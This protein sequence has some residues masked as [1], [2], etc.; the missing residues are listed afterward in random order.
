[1]GT[2]NMTRRNLLISLA[3]VAGWLAVSPVASRAAEPSRE[4]ILVLGDSITAAGGYVRAI[5][6]AL[7]KQDPKNAPRVVNRGRNSETVSGLSEAYHPGFRPCIFLRLDKVLNDTKPNWVL[8]CYGINCGIYHPFDE[9]RFAAY[10]AGIEKLIKKVHASG[11]RL[12]LF[13]PPPYA[14]SGPAFPKDA[15]AA[16]CKKLLAAASAKAAAEADKNPRK[17]GY[18]TPYAYYDSVMTRYAKW[19]ETLSSR[20]NVWVVNLRTAML[21]KLKECYN[22]DPIHPNGTGHGIMAAS[23]LKQWPEIRKSARKIKPPTPARQK[24]GWPGKKGDFHS[25]AMYSFQHDKFQCKVVVPK[26]IAKGKPWIWRARFW[27]HAPQFDIAMLNKG[28]HVVYADVAGL[29]GAPNAVARWD[30][31][32]KYLTESHGF[33]RKAVLEGMSRGGLIVF[34][35][36]SRN[37]RKVH[38]IYA[39]APVCDFKSWPGI[40]KHKSGERITPAIMTH[41]GFKTI[42]QVRAYKGNPI[43]NLKPLA[44]AGVALIH[45][46]GDADKVVPVADNTAVVE[47]RYKALGGVIEVIRKPGVGHRH[48]LKDPKPVVDFISKHSK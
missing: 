2:R 46:V 38:C 3:V 1:M 4:T 11:A 20:Q 7:K 28:F 6:A 8:A 27:G 24:R 17:Y 39:D 33:A 5:D 22:R 19:V 23:F 36:A 45:V 48:G 10:K 29:Y 37:P 21:P 12:V 41:Y 47:K 26:Q 30:S 35:W 43:D 14:R 32:Y 44:D 18:R 40:K 25:F 34:N 9:K 42:D 16:T 15:D 31:F 13:T